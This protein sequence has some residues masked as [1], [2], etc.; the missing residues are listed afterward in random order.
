AR[1]LAASLVEGWALAHDE[2]AAGV[3]TPMTPITPITLM[4]RIAPPVRAPGHFTT[5]VALREIPPTAITTVIRSGRARTRDVAPQAAPR[6]AV[7]RAA[8]R[9]LPVS[10]ALLA[11]A[12]IAAPSFI[13]DPVLSVGDRAPA[14]VSALRSSFAPPAQD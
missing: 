9:A 7:P 10:I 14:W 13:G 1:E 12:T 6:P 4:T 11:L 3:A 8:R 5:V 2:V